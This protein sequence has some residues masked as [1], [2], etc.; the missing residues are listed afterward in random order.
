M[1]KIRKVVLVGGGGHAKVVLDTVRLQGAFEVVG[2]VDAQLPSG[3][4]VEGVPVL[5]GDEILQS[6]FRQGVKLA[7]VAVG[8]AQGSSARELI[9]KKIDEIGFGFPNFVHPSSQ[10]AS[11][12]SLGSGILVAAGSV[13]QSGVQIED[14]AIINT[15]SSIDHDCRLGRFV[16]IAPGAVLSGGVQVGEGAHIGTGSVV[17]ENISIGERTLIGAGS[18]VVKNIPSHCKAF[19]NPC[20]VQAKL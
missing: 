7:F 6:I 13:L 14:H 16:H 9:F 4:I 12:V 17:I 11:S 1:K 5:G 3:K 2:L 19:G 20:H 8:S 15:Y 10:V 18:V